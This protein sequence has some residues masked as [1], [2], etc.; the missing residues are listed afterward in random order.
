[1]QDDEAGQRIKLLKRGERRGEVS[2]PASP[3]GRVSWY[4]IRTA[5]PSALASLARASPDASAKGS[6]PDL[7]FLLLLLLLLLL[8]LLLLVKRGLLQPQPSH[9]PTTTTVPLSCWRLNSIRTRDTMLDRS[10]SPCD[11]VLHTTHVIVSGGGCM[12]ST[13]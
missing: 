7:R 3:P 2:C 6:L 8:F 1:M 4:S 12:G 10:G 13:Y 5:N 11:R 9:N